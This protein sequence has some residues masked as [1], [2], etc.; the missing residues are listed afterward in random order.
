MSDNDA[1]VINKET[2]NFIDG[3][4][5]VTTVDGSDVFVCNNFTNNMRLTLPNFI[6]NEQ[7]QNEQDHNCDQMH[8]PKHLDKRNFQR[9]I[10]SSPA[11][12]RRFSHEVASISGSANRFSNVSFKVSY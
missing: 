10:Q 8:K 4:R 6:Q 12:Q 2:V 5:T 11:K 1:I 7:K 3:N 9:K